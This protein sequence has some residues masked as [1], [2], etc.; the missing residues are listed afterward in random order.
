MAQTIKLKFGTE[1]IPLTK[2]SYALTF[3]NKETKNETEAGTIG[4]VTFDNLPLQNL[5]KG[6]LVTKELTFRWMPSQTSFTQLIQ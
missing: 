4:G 3:Q 5:A 1:Y 6:E 2:G